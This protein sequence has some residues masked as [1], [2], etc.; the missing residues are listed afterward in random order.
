MARPKSS[1]GATGVM[2]TRQGN[3]RVY[4]YQPGQSKTPKFPWVY[5]MAVSPGTSLPDPLSLEDAWTD[6]RGYILFLRSVPGDYA[7]FQTALSKALDAA[8]AHTGFGWLQAQSPATGFVV[9]VTAK[10]TVSSSVRLDPAAGL[11]RL[12]IEADSSVALE[13]RGPAGAAAVA[14]GPPPVPAHSR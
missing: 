3:T 7:N 13:A 2:L 6:Y 9:A 1:V 5:W 12:E 4:L 10:S 8:P 11:P 14:I